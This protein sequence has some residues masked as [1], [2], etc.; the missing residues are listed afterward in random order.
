MSN[1]NS[2]CITE[3]A[4]TKSVWKLTSHLML[5]L[6]KVALMFQILIPAETRRGLAESYKNMTIGELST[7]VT[8]V[9]FRISPTCV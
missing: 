4:Y 6:Q 7:D 5:F 9:C 1:R 8:D 2:P 3:I